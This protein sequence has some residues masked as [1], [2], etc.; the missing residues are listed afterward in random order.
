MR[1]CVTPKH[2][3]MA[4]D[5]YCEAL[6]LLNLPIILYLS[7][8]SNERLKNSDNLDYKAFSSANGPMTVIPAGGA[9]VDSFICSMA[10][11][12]QTD[13]KALAIFLLESP[14]NLC[15]KPPPPQKP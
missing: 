7:D 2:Q 3:N 6:H 12:T 15:N 11:R 1:V 5:G 10:K 4:P 8:R 14:K 9:D 13:T